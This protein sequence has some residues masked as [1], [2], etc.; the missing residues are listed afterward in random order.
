[1]ANSVKYRVEDIEID[2]G[3]F[4]VLRLNEEHRLRPQTFKV[5]IFLLENSDR[6]VTKDELG[7]LW[8]DAEPTDDSFIQCIAEIRRAFGDTARNPRFIRTVPKVGYRFIAEVTPI[9]TVPVMPERTIPTITVSSDRP[10]SAHIKHGQWHIV[11]ISL[12]YAALYSLAIFVELASEYE[13]Y[14]RLAWQLAP[15]VFVWIAATAMAG[16][17]VDR[18]LTS[19]GKP[20]GLAISCAVHL[21]SAI[22]LFAVLR[23]FLPTEPTVQANFQT[24]PVPAAYLKSILYFLFLAVV[25]WL[26]AFHFVVAMQR[27]VAEGRSRDVWMLLMNDAGSVGPQ[28]IIYPR[29]SVLL[30]LWVI[31]CVIGLYMTFHLFDNLKPSPNLN[32]FMSLVQVR[33]SLFLLLGTSCLVWYNR[34]LNILK[35]QSLTLQN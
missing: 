13:R 19:A 9:E 25:F 2:A 16:L 5:L 27:E 32:L 7:S 10:G 29:F 14:G 11:A 21:G 35:H 8:D 15:I 12:V 22:L 17:T 18:G 20:N 34:A 24:F 33:F 1:M 26:P 6:V 4:A 3:T 23:L 28:G 31:V 30:R